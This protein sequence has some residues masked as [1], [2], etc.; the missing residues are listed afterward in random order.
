MIKNREL[1]RVVVEAGDVVVFSM[2]QLLRLAEKLKIDENTLIALYEGIPCQFGANGTFGV[3]RL[4]AVT[5]EGKTYPVVMI[6]G[7]PDKFLRFL[8]EGEQTF[9]DFY[10]NHPKRGVVGEGETF[11]R[12]KFEEIA[13]EYR[14]KLLGEVTLSAKPT[15][16]PPEAEQQF[17][18]A[19]FALHSGTT[20]KLHCLDDWAAAALL[21]HRYDNLE[22]NNYLS[23]EE[24]E[25][26]VNLGMVRDELDLDRVTTL[27]ADAAH[28]LAE[29]DGVDLRLNGLTT[30]SVEVAKELSRCS[31]GLHLDGLTT[32]DVAVAD[33]LVKTNGDTC[34]MSL[35]GLT[36]LSQ[37][38]AKALARHAHSTNG[39]S[40]TW[41]LSLNGLKTLTV[42]VAAALTGYGNKQSNF[43]WEKLSL[44]GLTDLSAE[45]ANM[46]VW[47]NEGCDSI[48]E[49]LSLNGLKSLTDELAQALAGHVGGKLSLNGLTKVS[50]T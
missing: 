7:E 50:D 25:E 22:A 27:S 49:H 32:L 44:D 1:G 19:T 15:P 6:G 21:A 24:V 42:E 48:C 33:A 8:R 34:W 3:D 20:Y 47:H 29:Y 45:V 28:E 43:R 23:A 18:A 5:E 11:N 46:L 9:H 10:E 39:E 41:T 40:F 30:L 13:V 17:E 4:V 16:A 31:V 36:C 37:E 26:L 2:D 35:D 38:A 14:K 12:A